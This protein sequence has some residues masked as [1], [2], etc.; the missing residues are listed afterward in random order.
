LMQFDSQHMLQD[1]NFWIHQFAD[2][3]ACSTDS[4]VPGQK[5]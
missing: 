3:L 2:A 4:H 5:P 1:I